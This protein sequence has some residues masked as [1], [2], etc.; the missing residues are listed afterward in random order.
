[1]P[2]N[3]SIR[4]YTNQ[5]RSHFHEFHQ[6]VL[7]LHG[8]ID[9]K[10]GD[11]TGKVSFGDCVIIK[12]GQQHDFRADDAARFIVVDME[13][14]PDNITGSSIAKFSINPPLLAYIQFID[15]QL[16]HQVNKQLESTAFALFYQ[17][18]AQQ[19]CNERIDPRIAEVIHFIKQDISVLFSIEQLAKIAC[20][21]TSQ[22]KKLFKQN[23]NM[24]THKY[25]TQLRMEKAS[26]LLAHTD[27][28]IRIVAEQVGYQ[29]LSAFSRRFSNYFGQSPKAFSH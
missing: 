26:A 29:D 24:T 2:N 9:I 17:L 8:A 20:L 5:I 4:A 27:L 23:M 7:P 19:A 3:L 12:A 10:V 13:N 6:L 22:Y 1:M 18:L 21:S 14:F 16:A 25:I 11:Y 15:K 28:P